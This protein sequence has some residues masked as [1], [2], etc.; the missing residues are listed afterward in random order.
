MPQIEG[1]N[2]YEFEFTYGEEL[3][4]VVI[5]IVESDASAV[6]AYINTDAKVV[7]HEGRLG[8]VLLE[9]HLALQE[10]TLRCSRIRNLW[11]SHHD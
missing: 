6:D 9:D 5:T 11:L 3:S 10:S 8:T 1:L 7:W 4:G 2:V